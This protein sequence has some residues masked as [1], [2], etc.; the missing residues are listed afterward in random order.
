MSLKRFF[1][2]GLFIVLGS[3]SIYMAYRIYLGYFKYKWG[4]AIDSLDEVNVYYNG[5]TS[6]SKSRNKING[7]NIGL[8]YQCVEFVKRYYYKHY[9]HKMPETYGHAKD[10]FDL[11]LEDGSFN[12]TRG[13]YQFTNPS[14]LKPEKG[15]LIVM[16]AGNEKY[17]HVAI[18]SKVGDDFVEII[19]QNAGP[20]GNSRVTYDLEKKEGLY[21]IH[22]KRINGWLR[23]Q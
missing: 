13:L 17:G 3:F 19:Q 14:H 20:F 2:I 12:K 15:D 18:V 4:D 9:H 6:T 1:T 10:F 16:G 23:K 7:Y 11:N 5:S 8:R 21:L 22:N